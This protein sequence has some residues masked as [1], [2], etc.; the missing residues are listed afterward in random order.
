MTGQDSICL[1]NPKNLPLEKIGTCKGDEHEGKR[2]N[3][4]VRLSMRYSEY[5]HSLSPDEVED[6]KYVKGTEKYLC[7]D[8]W[9]AECD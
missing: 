7:E 4:K 8:C 6:M 3:Q 5:D 2:R 9:G 1:F